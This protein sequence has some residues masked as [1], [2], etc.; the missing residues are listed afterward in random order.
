MSKSRG[1][2][3]RGRRIAVVIGLAATCGAVFLGSAGPASAGNTIVCGGKISPANKK[4]P[5]PE[6]KYTVQCSEGIRG[7]NVTTTKKLDFFGSETDVVPNVLQSAI[8]QC[9]GTVPGYGFGCGTVNQ[10]VQKNC[11]L[12]GKSPSCAT[13]V[14]A[15]GQQTKPDG[16]GTPPCNNAVDAGNF[17]SGDVSFANDPCDSNSKI[18]AYVSATS[19]PIVT[20]AA[21]ST[22]NAAAAD[23]YT[24]GIYSSQPFNLKVAGWTKGKCAKAGSDKSKEGT[25]K[26]K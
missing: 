15:C 3:H 20:N 21:G 17:I 1:S 14:A 9:E 5:G 23:S 25:S 18:K 11:G 4:K 26:K 2:A 24:T 7:F 16:T 8:L 12:G 22:T 10:F 13:N 6:A 19:T